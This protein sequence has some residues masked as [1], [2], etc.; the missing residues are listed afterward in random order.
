MS[1]FSRTRVNFEQIYF[2]TS[3]CVITAGWVSKWQPW[4][5]AAQCVLWH[6]IKVYMD[7][8]GLSVSV[9]IVGFRRAVSYFYVERAINDLGRQ[10]IPWPPFGTTCFLF[11]FMPHHLKAGGKAYSVYRVCVCVCVCVCM[12]ACVRACMCACVCFEITWQKYWPSWDDVLHTKPR[13]VAPS[14]RWHLEVKGKKIGFFFMSS[15]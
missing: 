6:L 8:S 15:P 13:S 12:R 10:M 3:S 7:W 9:L 4:S 2:I 14:S 11:V 5:D 1:G